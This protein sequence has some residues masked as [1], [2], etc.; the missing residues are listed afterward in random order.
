MACLKGPPSVA[1]HGCKWESMS[2]CEF[3]NISS[4]IMLHASAMRRLKSAKYIWLH[5]IQLGFQKV[6][7]EKCPWHLGQVIEEAIRHIYHARLLLG[8]KCWTGSYSPL[9]S[10]M[11]RHRHGETTRIVV[12]SEEDNLASP[13]SS[14]ISGDSCALL[15]VLRRKEVE[16]AGFSKYSTRLFRPPHRVFLCT[17]NKRV[18]MCM[19]RVFSTLD[20]VNRASLVRK[21]LE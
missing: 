7:E 6:S 4:V 2:R 15:I 12:P 19:F 17:A 5:R 13:L 9:L 8:R 21:T 16:Q 20:H 1:I 3:T 18:H 11:Q 14:I 10:T